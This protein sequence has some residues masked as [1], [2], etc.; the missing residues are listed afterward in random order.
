MASI[1]K[2]EFD[3]YRANQAEMVSKYD[4]K[5]I[6]IKD[7]EVLGV[8]E[9]DLSAVSEVQKTHPLGTFLVQR[10]SAGEEA[11]TMTINSPGVVAS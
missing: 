5:V 11:Y 1:L 3:F 6:A 2:K 9:S 7:G 4:G 10:V 8:F